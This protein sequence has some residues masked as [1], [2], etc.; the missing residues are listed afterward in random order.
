MSD[1]SKNG[2]ASTLFDLAVTLGAGAFV[3]LSFSGL[4]NAYAP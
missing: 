1:K 3:F 4:L 2:A